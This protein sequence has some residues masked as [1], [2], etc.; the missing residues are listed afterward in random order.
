MTAV[1]YDT[2][3][4][5]NIFRRRENIAYKRLTTDEDTNVSYFASD[6][7]G[8]DNV[9]SVVDKSSSLVANGSEFTDDFTIVESR[10]FFT[11]ESDRLLITDQ[12]ISIQGLSESLPLFYQHILD[13]TNLPR[14]ST[15]DMD[16]AENIVLTNVEILDQNMNVL[17]NLNLDIDYDEG[18]IYNDFSAVRNALNLIRYV[19]YSVKDASNIIKYYTEI[20]Y[21]QDI[22]TEALFSDLDEE[23]NIINDGRKVFLANR[24]GQDF[25]VVLPTST[26]YAYKIK[27]NSKIKIEPFDDL[28]VD[29][30]WFA[31]ILNG[32]FFATVSGTTYRYHIAEFDTQNWNPVGPYKK[33]EEEKSTYLSKKLIK[34]NRKNIYQSSSDSL[35]VDVLINNEVGEAVAA[36]TTDSSKD[37]TIASNGSTFSKYSYSNQTGIR[38]IDSVNGILDIVGVNLKSNYEIISSYSF[39]EEEYEFTLIDFNPT[40]NLDIYEQKVVLFVDSEELTEDESR[41]LS[42]L[43]VDKKGQVIESNYSSFSD[44][45]KLLDDGRILVYESSFASSLVDFSPSVGFADAVPVD[46]T[47]RTSGYTGYLLGVTYGNGLFMIVGFNGKILTSPDGKTWTSQTSGVTT[48][49]RA[50][51]YGNGIFVVVGDDGVIL[52]SSD[53]ETWTSQ[54]SEAVNEIYGVTYGNDLFVAVGDGGVILTSPDGETWTSQTSGLGVS[55]NGITY[56]SDLFVVVGS[57]GKILT[58][59]DG[60]TW[61]SQTSGLVSTL[62]GATYGDGLFVVITWSNVVLV[63]SNGID[64]TSYPT[65]VSSWIYAAAYGNGLFTITTDDGTILTSLDGTT[66]TRQISGTAEDLLGITYSNGLFVTAGESGTILTSPIYTTFLSDLSTEG[67]G[68]F[69]TLGEMTVGIDSSIDDAT[70]ID[71]RI[72]GGGIKEDLLSAAKE[73]N[74]EVNWYWDIGQ[75]DGI[76]YPGTASYLVEI[77]VETFSG[78]GGIS[79]QKRATEVIDKHTALGVYPLIKAYGVDPVITSIIPY[80]NSIQ[81]AWSSYGADISYYIYYSVDGKS[82]TVANGSVLPDAAGGNTYTITGLDTGVVYRISV[83]GGKDIDGTWTQLSGQPIG[84]VDIGVKEIDNP[85]IF[86][87]KTF[88]ASS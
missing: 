26:N 73:A 49:L 28:D 30:P 55:L 37:A 46:W 10:N 2:D 81:I 76:P 38:S 54:T 69:L 6:I 59:S 31:R 67:D 77:P 42:Y 87:A 40:H 68:T 63:S 84:P 56:G 74:S 52:T 19:Q 50:V 80:A 48:P 25:D 12:F 78:A 70:I 4:L 8:A 45:T 60:E 1:Q 11:A 33:T 36:F 14:V 17:E 65:G 34:L 35:Y 9:V 21:N 16:L 71:T 15:S 5:L 39:E 47:S 43:I 22:Y 61:T 53:G 75:W 66:W 51:T 32:S 72:P 13:T 64:W 58:S 24:I 85:N 82:W 29:I 62:Y 41:T 3:I 44:D 79:T 88:D 86:I 23:L 27:N 18:I 7:F 20:F 57:G 83:V